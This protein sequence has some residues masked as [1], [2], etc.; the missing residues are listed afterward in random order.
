MTASQSLATLE[1]FALYVE[2]GAAD[3]SAA[4]FAPEA[5][6]SEPPSFAL[7]GRP[8]IH[9]FLTDF[10][11]RHHT[12][13]FALLRTLASPDGSLVAAEW[14]FAH[15]RDADGERKVYEGMSWT[16]FADGLIT[17]WHGYSARL[18]LAPDARATGDEE[19]S[20]G[21]QG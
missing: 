15:T 7:A 18:D 12:V 3:A 2:S 8:A 16:E 14:R 11:D 6:Y 13:T 9:A 19:G 5:T 17:R 21:R 10:A 1:R 4:L 20:A